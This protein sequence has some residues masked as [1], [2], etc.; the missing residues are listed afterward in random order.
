MAY[1]PFIAH[2]FCEKHKGAPISINN[3]NMR[4]YLW[5]QEAVKHLKSLLFKTVMIWRSVRTGINRNQKRSHS[6]FTQQGH[7]GGEN[8][9][10][11]FDRMLIPWKLWSQSTAAPVGPNS[12]RPPSQMDAVITSKQRWLHCF[13][14]ERNRLQFDP[15]MPNLQVQWRE[16]KEMSN[17]FQSQASQVGVWEYLI[18]LLPAERERDHAE[19]PSLIALRGVDSL[20]S[21]T[22]FLTGWKC[23]FPVTGV[24]A[25]DLM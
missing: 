20:S 1:C 5:T 4:C 21:A 18:I 23:R 2:L 11:P 15:T 22:A 9:W 10:Q 17:C 14:A 7:T 12:A 8:T 16:F 25:V 3:N 6:P 24:D 19:P 13:Q